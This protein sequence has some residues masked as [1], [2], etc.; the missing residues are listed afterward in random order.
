MNTSP[1][2]V[3]LVGFM[4]TGKTCVGEA[5]A[6]RLGYKYVDTDDLIEA[7]AGKEISSIF[8]EDG[9]THFRALESKIA[10]ELEDFRNHVIATGGGIIKTDDNIAALNRAGT[11]V[12]L[13]ARPEVIYERVREETHRPLLQVP[14]PQGRIVELLAERRA[15]YEK[16]GYQ[17]DTSD[18]SPDQV[19]DHII[20]IMRR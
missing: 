9:E 14:D 4:G 16:S 5:L 13:S 2:N 18:L 8:A 10:T 17:L 3:L 19:V 15:Q 7:R 20:T 12:C 11:V 6:Q 1:N